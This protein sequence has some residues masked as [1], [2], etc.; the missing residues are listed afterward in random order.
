M[1]VEEQTL[2]NYV[3]KDAPL[4]WFIFAIGIIIII[5]GIAHVYGQGLLAGKVGGNVSTTTS[6]TEG[7]TATQSYAQNIA[8]TFFHPKII[9]LLFIFLVAV[10]TIALLTREAK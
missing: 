5:S 2:I 1:G 7:G 6:L 3:S 8:S 4:A 9:G 10:F